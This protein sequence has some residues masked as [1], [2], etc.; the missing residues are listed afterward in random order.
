MSGAFD[1]LPKDYQDMLSLLRENGVAFLV[2]GGWAMAAHGFPRATKD[3]DVLVQ[4]TPEN[5]PKV[6]R[7]L[8]AFGAPLREVT[9]EDFEA[10]GLI[11][12]IGVGLRIDITTSIEGVTFEEAARDCTTVDLCG[13]PIPV[14][15]RAALIQNKRVS[16]RD[17]DRADVRQLE[18]HARKLGD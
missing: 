18:K 1:G 7:T 12:Q 11:L 4:A 5:A 3:L 17:Q 8:A 9:V 15:G 16:D 6:Y 2:V 13:A 10:P 14:I